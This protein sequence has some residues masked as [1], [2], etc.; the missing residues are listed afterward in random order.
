MTT[1]VTA[2][3]QVRKG[4][5]AQWT[6]ANPTLLSG[7][8]GFETDT[9]KV[10]IGDGSTAWTGLGYTVDPAAVHITDHGALTGLADDDHTQYHTDARGDAR[11]ALTGHN[12]SGVYEVSG[13]VATHAAVTSSVHGISTFGASLVDDANAGTAR[14]TLGLGTAATAAAGDFAAASH[15]HA[16]SAIISGT[17]DTARLGS[18]SASS[19]TYLRGD[20]TWAAVSGGVASDTHAATDKTTPVGA[21]ELPLIDSAASFV[22]KKLTWANIKTTLAG[23]FATLAG[24]SGGQ[25]LIGGTAVDDAL[26]LQGTSGNGTATGTALAVKVGNN[27]ATTALTVLNNGNVGVGTTSPSKALFVI[28]DIYASKSSG[29]IT[30]SA[31]SGAGVFDGA[32]FSAVGQQETFFN[33]ITNSNT[34]GKRVVRFGNKNNKFVFQ[35]LNDAADT[36]TSEPVAIEVGAPTGSVYVKSDGKFGIGTASPSSLCHA[37]STTE[38]LRLGYD[39]SNYASFTVDSAGNLTL[40]NTGTTPSTYIATLR[41]GRKITAVTTTASPAAT[42]AG[43]VYTNE[44]DVDGATITLPTAAAG[45]NFIA[46]VQTAQT[47]TITANSGDTIR[48]ASNVTAAAG[49]ITSNVVGSSVTL[50]AINATEWVAIA[51]I[52]SWSF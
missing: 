43:T 2:K 31:T 48:I 20:Q 40:K 49:S 36:I 50:V 23:T 28:G 21:D 18:G 16:A 7:E 44:G 19:S 25:T 38:Q 51:S 45:L 39:S 24:K 52:G 46:Y 33:I 13:A 15:A 37:I 35:T 41:S 4:T 27:G 14:T 5:A 3:I 9:G 22:L 11:Y 42:D 47:L 17:I 29:G 32:Y 1:T 8:I 26:S 10:K 12:H 30:F 34:S 6:S